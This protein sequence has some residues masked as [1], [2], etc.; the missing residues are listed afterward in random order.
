[1]AENLTDQERAARD[2][3]REAEEL[4]PDEIMMDASQMQGQTFVARVA[5]IKTTSEFVLDREGNAL[6][7]QGKFPFVTCLLETDFMEEGFYTWKWRVSNSKNGTHAYVLQAIGTVKILDA[8]GN[9]TGN[10]G[11]KGL[12]SVMQLLNQTF[13]FEKQ[14]LE[15]GTDRDGNKIV[16]PNFPMPIE[17]YLPPE[18]DESE[19]GEESDEAEETETE[20]EKAEEG[21]TE[22]EEEQA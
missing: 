5:D 13:K 12:T 20:E 10:R 17:Y 9:D 4:N 7:E 22:A 1:M 8:D 15:F 2:A 3:A 19:G 11:I 18:G 21:E 14:D 16:K 6:K